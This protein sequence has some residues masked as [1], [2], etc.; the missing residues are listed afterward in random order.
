MLGIVTCACENQH[1]VVNITADKGNRFRKIELNH[2]PPTDASFSADIIRITVFSLVHYFKVIEIRFFFDWVFG[3]SLTSWW[4][5]PVPAP[6]YTV[7][8]WS[9]WSSNNTACVTAKIDPA[10]ISP[11]RCL[12]TMKRRWVK[13]GVYVWCAWVCEYVQACPCENKRKQEKTEGTFVTCGKWLA[14]W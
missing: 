7:S 10:V 5:S 11:D 13:A 6:F 9:Q 8:Q 4:I 2:I 1:G 12:M 14:W 3:S